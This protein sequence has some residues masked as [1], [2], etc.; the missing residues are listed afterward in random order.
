VVV[1]IVLGVVVVLAFWFALAVVLAL[2]IGRAARLGEIKHRD[3]VF[4]REAQQARAASV[5]S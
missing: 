5:R 4:L 2:L 3:A 1:P